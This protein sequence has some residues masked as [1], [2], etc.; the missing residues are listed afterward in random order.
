MA[1]GIK[2]M[3]HDDGVFIF[4]AQY[5][6]DI[7][8]GMLVATIFHEH[9]SHHSVGAM[10][11]FLDSHNMELIEV[12]R[13]SIQH[14]S[15]IGT[16]Q[17]KGG[18]YPVGDSVREMVALEDGRKLMDL[19]TLREWSTKLQK[20]RDR[21][22]DLVTKWKGKN[23]TIAG[24]GAARSGPTLISQMGLTGSIDFIV[25]DHPQKVGRYSP[26][27]GIYIFPTSELV[28]K[29]PDYT[30]IL[31]W[32]HSE[33]I[34]AENQAYLEKGGHFVVLCPETR[35]VGKDGEVLI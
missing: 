19:D 25:D 27:D 2:F 26:G 33:K 24:F 34:I 14:G 30:I 35:V 13:A 21:T 31:A 16:V 17:H 32:V 4:E 12:E 18:K 15:I 22:V 1:E 3:M 9:M 23:A 29:M 7:L 10:I 11:R 5:L 28:K 20:L 8:D 6:L